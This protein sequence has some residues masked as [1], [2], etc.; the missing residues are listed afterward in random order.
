MDE[1]EAPPIV[2]TANDVVVAAIACTT[3]G[4][5][6][7]GLKTSDQCPGCKALVGDSLS[8]RSLDDACCIQCGYQLRGLQADGVCPECGTP[9]DRSLHGNG[10]RYSSLAY[11][12][13]LRRGAWMIIAA[14]ILQILISLGSGFIGAVAVT[15]GG[16]ASQ[17]TLFQLGMQG[18][19]MLAAFMSL[20]GWWLFSE[21]DPAYS[22]RDQGATSRKV[23][24][25]ALVI[26]AAQTMVSFALQAFPSMQGGGVQG[27][28]APGVFAGAMAIVS[29]GVAAVKFFASMLY[30]RWLAP[31]LPN[32]RVYR[33]AKTLMWLGP[34]LM[35]VGCMILVGPLIALVLYWNLIYWMYKDLKRIEEE[36]TLEGA[37]AVA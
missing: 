28:G 7:L 12:R 20:Y 29:V 32:A 16:S 11:V 10:L 22:G 27:G 19:M 25:W 26:A 15:S 35:T 13:S 33:R 6:L 34:V 17:T 23:V 21:L 31:R 5:S 37:L 1:P 24:R 3:C 18:L 9:V 4:H 30:I 8:T 2:E 14:I 36:I